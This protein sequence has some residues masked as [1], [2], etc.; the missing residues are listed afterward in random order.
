MAKT[1]KE[2]ANGQVSKGKNPELERFESLS[3]R[4][5]AVPKK[6]I[7]RKREKAKKTA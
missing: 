2:P 6:E 3:R 5:L 4:L 1:S 7:D